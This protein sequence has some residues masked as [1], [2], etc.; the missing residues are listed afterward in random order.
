MVVPWGNTIKPL[1][2]GANN[3]LPQDSWKNFP[4]FNG[5]GKVSADEHITTFFA[6]CNIVNPQHEDVA[7][8]M[9]VETLIENA[10]DWFQHLPMGCITNWNDMKN[11]FETHYKSIED[12][13][14]L[15]T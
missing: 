9:F 15:L 12:E 8:R 6:A 7:V 13:H 10:T 14:T 5:D 3:N 11:C 2:L 1:Q 4:K